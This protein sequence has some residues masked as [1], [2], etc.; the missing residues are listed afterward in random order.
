MRE[1][2]Y[3]ERFPSEEGKPPE[4]SGNLVVL[5]CVCRDAFVLDIVDLTGDYEMRYY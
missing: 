2:D 3:F 1:Y 5:D 4:G